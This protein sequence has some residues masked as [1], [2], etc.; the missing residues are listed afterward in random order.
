MASD[1]PTTTES[2]TS[3]VQSEV[4]HFNAQA[5]QWWDPRGSSAMLHR[6]NPVRLRFIRRAIDSHW[7]T[8]SHALRPLA[9]KRSLD[10]GCGAGLVCEPLARLGA[11]ATGLDAA[12]DSIAAARD[13]AESQGL[14]ISY[15]Q[16]RIEDLAEAPFDLVTCLEVIEHVA[17][18]DVFVGHL[19]RLLAPGGLMILS[20]P[21]RTARSRVAM[22]TLGEG[23]GMI[24][25][26]THDWGKFLTPEEL[27]TILARHGLSVV[28]R[29]GIAFG[30]AQGFTLSEDQGLNYILS[31]IRG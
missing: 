30:P 29:T 13:H 11:D 4:D 18:P 27:E 16:G 3:I 12:P 21:N 5:A 17:D 8:D 31:A 26:G 1:A 6:I 19:A 15:R 10:V 23:L 28:T 7:G 2:R 22:I 24:P 14:A 20:T 25:R 9:G